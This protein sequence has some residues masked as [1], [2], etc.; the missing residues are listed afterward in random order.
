M[1]GAFQMVRPQVCTHTLFPMLSLSQIFVFSP[2]Y[3]TR[4]SVGLLANFEDYF[5]VQAMAS[6]PASLQGK[7]IYLGGQPYMLQECSGSDV[8]TR[9]CLTHSRFVIIKSGGHLAYVVCQKL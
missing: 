8:S 4:N 6:G 9:K 1:L 3:V 5:T 7:I 2:A